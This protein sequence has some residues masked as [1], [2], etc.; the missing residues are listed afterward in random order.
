MVSA[1]GLSIPFWRCTASSAS[2]AAMS[3]RVDADDARSLSAVQ[4][5]RERQM[6]TVFA[7][8]RSSLT[9][10]EYCPAACWRVLLCWRAL[11]CC[12]KIG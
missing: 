2:S 4:H 11:Q 9:S 5:E 10:A 12:V 3:S 1:S 6:D 8:L 7:Q